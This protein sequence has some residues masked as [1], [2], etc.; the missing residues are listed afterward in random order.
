MWRCDVVVMVLLVAAV[1]L[2]GLAAFKVTTRLVDLGW[3]GVFLYVLAVAT[4]VL[5]AAV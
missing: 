5:D 4:P 1:V 2:L 3:L